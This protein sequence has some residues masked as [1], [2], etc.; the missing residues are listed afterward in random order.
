[1]LFYVDLAVM[2]SPSVTIYSNNILVSEYLAFV[3][4]VACLVFRGV[5]LGVIEE[6]PSLSSTRIAAA[7]E[8]SP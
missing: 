3:N 8:L 6:S 1:M 5:A 4:I 2:L 7:M